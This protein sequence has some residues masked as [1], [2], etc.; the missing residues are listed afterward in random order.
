MASPAEKEHEIARALVLGIAGNQLG[1]ARAMA[2]K[3][4]RQAAECMKRGELAGH[5][6]LVC[7]AEAFEADLV[8]WTRVRDIW[9]ARQLDRSAG[10]H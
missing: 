10:G 8:I 4:R 9:V 6:A 3:S 1:F 5:E 2:L 7:L